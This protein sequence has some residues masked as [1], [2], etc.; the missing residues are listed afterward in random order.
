[1]KS[2]RGLIDRAV[3][4]RENLKMKNIKAGRFKTV[5]LGIMF[6]GMIVFFASPILALSA[7]TITGSV[8][9]GST[10]QPAA[11]EQIVLL[12][13]VNDATEQGHATTD[14]Q[15]SFSLDVDAPGKYIL[16]AKHQGVSYD[17]N[18]ATGDTVKIPVFDTAST[19][20]GLAGVIAVIRVNLAR[21]GLLH[22]SQMYAIRN[23]SN[24]SKT[25]AG[26]RAFQVYLPPDGTIDSVLAAGPS[27]IAERISAT[28][29]KGEPGHYTIN[30]PLRP[31]DT[32]LAVNYDLPYTGRQMFRPRLVYG[33]KQLA[34]MFPQS[35]QFASDSPSFRPILNENGYSVEA[36]TSVPAGDGLSFELS[37]RGVLA[38]SV[39]SGHV[40]SAQAANSQAP[41]LLSLP[42]AVTS[43][44]GERSPKTGTSAGAAPQVPALAQNSVR[45]TESVLE[46]VPLLLLS[47][48]VAAAGVGIFLWRTKTSPSA[49]V[50]GFASDPTPLEALKEEFLLLETSRLN[51]AITLGQYD[52]RKKVLEKSMRRVLKAA[53]GEN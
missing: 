37:G 38:P 42:A 8:V 28:P 11:G 39:S 13:A 23:Q 17:M 14:A 9:N 48:V 19:V 2:P 33:V 30:F 4:K 10:G 53:T 36:A 46:P 40:Q 44:N 3:L 41:A 25:L 34:I 35:M 5:R 6:A 51:G 22:I 12:R 16:R 24:P 26:G 49:V 32:N 52:L 15:G 43:A 45:W 1:M 31:G 47:I 29:V 50:A 21:K 20:D 7:N 18:V 27:R